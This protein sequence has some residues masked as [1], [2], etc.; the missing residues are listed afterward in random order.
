L[1]GEAHASG[2]C[3]RYLEGTAPGTVFRSH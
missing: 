1:M 2:D 3:A